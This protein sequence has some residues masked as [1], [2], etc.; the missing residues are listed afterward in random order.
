METTRSH[1]EMKGRIEDG[2]PAIAIRLVEETNIAET[3]CRIDL[4]DP[5]TIRLIEEEQRQNIIKLMQNAVKIVRTK[6]KTD[7]FGFGQA[8]YRADPKAWRSLRHDWQ[9]HFGKL[10]IEYEVKVHIRKIGMTQT[11]LKSELKE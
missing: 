11:S 4:D 3:D 7:V 6:Y 2:E 5:E 10:K 9:R 1:T 8:I